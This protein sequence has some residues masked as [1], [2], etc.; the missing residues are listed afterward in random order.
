MP[1]P[2]AARKGKRQRFYARNAVKTTLD[3]DFGLLMRSFRADPAKFHATRIHP[4]LTSFADEIVGRLAR[5]VA[6]VVALAL[7][8]IVGIPLLDQLPDANAMEPSAKAGW[9]LATRSSRAVCRHQ[10]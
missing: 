5:L 7:L 3:A 6:Y 1:L 9:S 10:I 4:A 8:A 2:A